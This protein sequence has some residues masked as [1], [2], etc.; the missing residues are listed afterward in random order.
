MDCVIF[1]SAIYMQNKHRSSQEKGLTAVI[2]VSTIVSLIVRV[3]ILYYVLRVFLNFGAG[4]RQRGNTNSIVLSFALSVL[5]AL[6]VF[7]AGL[8]RDMPDIF[9]S[10]TIAS[11][12]LHVRFC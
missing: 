2:F 8:L 3:C 10:V 1:Q 4:L 9:W 12:S 5:Q 6:T 11:V 7:A